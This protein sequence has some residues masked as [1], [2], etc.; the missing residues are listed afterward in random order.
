MGIV[1][2]LTLACGT[3]RADVAD[4]CATA[5]ETAQS[6]LRSHRLIDAKKTLLTCARDACPIIVRK[7]CVDWLAQTTTRIPKVVFRALDSRGHDVI[8]ARVLVDGNVVAGHLDGTAIEVDPGRHHVRF[9]AHGAGAV[10]LDVLVNEGEVDR[11]IDATF[12]VPLTLEGA[13]DESSPPQEGVPVSKR[14][15]AFVLGGIGIAALGAFAIL[16]A[17]TYSDYKNVR[18]GCGRTPSCSSSELASLRTRFD[19]AAI[20][21]GVGVVS[22]GISS[23]LFIRAEPRAD[24]AVGTV[25]MRF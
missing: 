20:A 7:D 10:A 24:G 1:G 23:W 14:T 4:E 17:T 9:E 11:L 8:G 19:L 18:D 21:L 13:A 16:D 5:A 12:A 3:A 25:G 6:L 15:A 2:V 22:L